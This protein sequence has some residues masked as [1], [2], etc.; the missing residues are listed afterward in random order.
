MKNNNKKL[1]LSEL[2]KVAGGGPEGSYVHIG[3]MVINEQNQTLFLKPNE[4][5]IDGKSYN[6]LLMNRVAPQTPDEEGFEKLFLSGLYHVGQDG[7]IQ[8]IFEESEFLYNVHVKSNTSPLEI[9]QILAEE[10]WVRFN[11]DIYINSKFPSQA[12]REK[13]NSDPSEAP[14][15]PSWL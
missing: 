12:F 6:H 5:P 10:K 1:S 14:T 9:T 4:F 7:K 2:E 11:N 13:S 8:C 3:Y 15:V